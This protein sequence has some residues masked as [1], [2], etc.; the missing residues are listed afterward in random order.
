MMGTFARAAADGIDADLERVFGWF[1]RLRSARTSTAGLLS[2][3][4]QQM[5]AIGRAL[6]AARRAAARR[7]LAGP[8]AAAHREI[9]AIVRR[10]NAEPAHLHPGG[11]AERGHRA[12]HRRR[13]LRHGA[14]PHRRGRHLRRA[15]GQDDVKEFYLGR[16]RRGPAHGDG[17][18]QRWKRRKTMAVTDERPHGDPVAFGHDTPPAVPRQRCQDW[19][20]QPALRHKQ[21]HLASASLGPV[22]RQRARRRAGA[23]R[24]GLAQGDAIAC[25]PKTARGCYA[26]MG[27]QCMG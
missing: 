26:D 25:W 27:A 10:I 2:G 19:A 6:M 20:A 15:D 14:G 9:F 3:G 13:R 7:A 8:V 12:G 16:R 5:L 21:G 1:P 4:E 18:K 23:G 22:L 17:H 11:G 24:A